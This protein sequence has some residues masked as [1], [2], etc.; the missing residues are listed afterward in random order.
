MTMM[1]SKF[2]RIIQSKIVW[3]AFAV[4]ISVAF[5]SITVPGSRN[6]STARRMRREAQ[7]AGRMFGED[8]S[9]SEFERARQSVYVNYVL[10][11]GRPITVT[12]EID[13]LLREAAWQ[14]IAMLKKARQLG[15]TVSPQQTIDMIQSQ[16]LFQNQKTGQF[17]KNAYDAFVTGFLPRSTGMNAKDL[18]NMFAEQVLLEKVSAIPVQGALVFEDE[19]KRAFHLYT[20]TL[21]VEYAAIPRSLADA[22]KIDETDA[23]NYFESHPEEFRMPEKVMVDYVRFAVADHTNSV[24]V[25]DKMVASFYE[26]NKQRFAKQPEEGTDPDAAPEFIPLEEVKDKIADGLRKQL[27]RSAATD[28]ADELVSALADEWLTFKDAAKNAGLEIVG[29]TPAFAATDPVKGV[30][31]TAPFQDAAFRLQKD[32]AHYYSDPVVGRDFVYV[33]ALTKKLDSFLPSFDVVRK[34]VFEAAKLAAAQEAYTEKAEEI[35]KEIKAALKGGSSFADAIAKYKLEPKTVGPF[36][37]TDELDDEFGK[38]IKQAA[39]YVEQGKATD[40]LCTS[41]GFMV[42][43]MA[44]RVPGDEATALPPMRDELVGSIKRNKA[45]LLVATWREDLLKEAGFED[46]SVHDKS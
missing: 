25:T 21:T 7:L 12:E 28:Q 34:D 26:N 2:H 45:N 17:D 39:A 46:L 9:R 32:A 10:R 5:V 20:D 15:M 16:P 1:I 3:G 6:R 29:N 4:L 33:I 24:V 22:P 37:V 40:L 19:I 27:A 23:K 8:V 44:K 18:E 43:Y 13:K 31:P 35:Q 14:R 42:A 30:D 38:E 41:K 11:S 36:K